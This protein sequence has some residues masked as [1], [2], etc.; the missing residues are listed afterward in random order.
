[1]SRHDLKSVTMVQEFE[2][3][4]H[5]LFSNRNKTA[6]VILVFFLWNY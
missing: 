3:Y 1:M 5:R 6:S 4:C 2:R